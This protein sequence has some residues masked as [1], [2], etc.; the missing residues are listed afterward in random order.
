MKTNP[1]PQRKKNEVDAFS[2]SFR[3]KKSPS[4]NMKIVEKV[5]CSHQTE[6]NYPKVATCPPRRKQIIVQPPVQP[7][8]Y[9]SISSDIDVL[10]SIPT[11]Y[12]FDSYMNSWVSG[13]SY[14]SQGSMFAPVYYPIS[15]Y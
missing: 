8:I 1:V 4:S 7:E 6:R 5:F 3:L 11:P 14:S 13:S 9:S 15:R 12:Y 10:E 2:F